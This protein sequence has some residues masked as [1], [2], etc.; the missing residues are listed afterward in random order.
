MRSHAWPSSVATLQLNR[1]RVTPSYAMLRYRM[2]AN[3]SQRSYSKDSFLVVLANLEP[4]G[5]AREQESWTRVGWCCGRAVDSIV[6]LLC[7]DM[8]LRSPLTVSGGKQGPIR[9]VGPHGNQLRMVELTLHPPTRQRAFRRPTAA[10]PSG[11]R[12]RLTRGRTERF[13]GQPAG[14]EHWRQSPQWKHCS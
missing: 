4:Q 7:T 9:S 5:S 14:R 6:C 10:M 11:R 1:R 3:T 13:M 8:L 2:V 12:R